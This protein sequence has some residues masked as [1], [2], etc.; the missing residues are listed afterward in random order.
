[1]NRKSP[2][3][4]ELKISENKRRNSPEAYDGNQ[5]KKGEA[6]HTLTESKKEGTCRAYKGL[7]AKSGQKQKKGRLK[8]YVRSESRLTAEKQRL[9]YRA[10]YSRKE[11]SLRKQL[12]I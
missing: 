2:S 9:N 7:Q 10:K 3:K 12:H 1:M 8:V 4:T 5:K 11:F 6:A